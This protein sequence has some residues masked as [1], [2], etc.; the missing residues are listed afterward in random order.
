ML[1][2]HDKPLSFLRLDRL[3]L[4]RMAETWIQLKRNAKKATKTQ[5][6]R[7]VCAKA[8]EGDAVDGTSNIRVGRIGLFVV[9]PTVV[10]I[11]WDW[12]VMKV[13]GSNIPL[14]WVPIVVDFFYVYAWKLR[15]LFFKSFRILDMDHIFNPTRTGGGGGG[16][17]GGLVGPR[18]QTFSHNSRMNDS[19]ELKF[20]DFS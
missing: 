14:G 7:K 1:S 20:S 13:V 4:R 5:S 6:T 10:Y 18:S 3:T 16:G 12:F 9:V 15:V 17:G 8:F 11:W 19:N 2:L